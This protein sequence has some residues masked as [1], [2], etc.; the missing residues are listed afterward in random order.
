ATKALKRTGPPWY[1]I[2]FIVG[3]ALPWCIAAAMAWRRAKRDGAT[4]YAVLW[5]LLP[6]LF[7]SISQS[8]RPQY[9]LP[10]MPAIA[11]LAARLWTTDER[12]SRIAARATAVVFV[13]LGA[14]ILAV[15]LLHV[16]MDPEVAA[17]ARTSA[18]PMGLATLAGALA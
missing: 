16:K 8:K 7:F 9:I 1:F 6:F 11:L 18:L 4:V 3:G 12:L 15:P 5:V 10:V 17:T 13:I 2:P 14:A